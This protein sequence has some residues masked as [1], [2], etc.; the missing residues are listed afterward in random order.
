MQVKRGLALHYKHYQ[1]EQSPTDQQSYAAAE[2][3]ASGAKLGLWVNSDHWQPGC[4]DTKGG[5]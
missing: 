4:F 1:R 3:E 5:G 2:I